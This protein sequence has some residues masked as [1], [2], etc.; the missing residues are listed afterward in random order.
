MA[1]SEGCSGART[2]EAESG[3]RERRGPQLLLAEVDPLCLLTHRI[4]RRRRRVKR[5]AALARCLILDV[6]TFA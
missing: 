1:G 4:L 5:A 3:A 6:P 2:P